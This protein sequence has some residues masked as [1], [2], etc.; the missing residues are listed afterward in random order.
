MG[1]NKRSRFFGHDA[2][3][4]EAVFEEP[5]PA[6]V[7]AIIDKRCTDLVREALKRDAFGDWDL[8]FRS[9][10]MQG[11]WDG[12]IAEGKKYQPKPEDNLGAGI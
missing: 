5:M 10:Y 12:A 8:A 1:R 9:C 2:L 7:A 11:F 3:N 4:R 6:P